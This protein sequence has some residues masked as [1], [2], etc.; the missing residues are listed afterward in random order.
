MADTG[1]RMA[2]AQASRS[3][4]LQ[5]SAHALFLSST[6]TSRYLMTEKS[7]L[8]HA[9]ETKPDSCLA[10]GSPLLAG[11]TASF[12]LASTKLKSTRNTK[13]REEQARHKTRYL[14]CEVCHRVSKATVTYPLKSKH[15]RMMQDDKGPKLQLV[16]QPVPESVPEKSTKAMSSKRRAKA[17]RDREGLQNL[18]NRSSQ[19]RTAPTL[20]LMDLMKK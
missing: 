5:G 9:T 20:N 2:D 7:Q 12:G 18:L 11:W 3:R 6:S 17:R 14:K 19:N 4:F 8:M 16:A 15:K 1:L 10:C 13:G